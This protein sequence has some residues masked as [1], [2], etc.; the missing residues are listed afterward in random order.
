MSAIYRNGSWYCQ[1]TSNLYPVL[2]ITY[3]AKG[4][5]GNNF[6]ITMTR[7]ALSYTQTVTGTTGNIQQDLKSLGVWSITISDGTTTSR[8]VKV[9]VTEAVIY[10]VTVSYGYLFGYDLKQND[11][12]PNTRVTYPE[13]VHNAN[14]EPA[15]MDFTSD[16][17]RCGDWHFLETPGQFFMPKPVMLSAAGAV[18]EYLDPNDYTKTITGQ[19]SHVSD[20]SFDGNAMI[21]WPKIY[22]KRTYQNNTYSFRCS[23]VQLDDD[24]D[25][26]SNY[27]ENNNIKDYFYTPIYFG[28]GSTSRMR[29]LSGKNNLVNT[30]AEQEATAARANGAG[31]DVETFCDRLLIQD[32]AVLISKSTHSQAKFGYGRGNSGNSSAIATGTMDTKGMF[33]GDTAG[34]NGVKIFGMQNFYGNLWRRI[35]GWILVNG[36]QKVKLTRGTHDGSTATDYNMTGDGYITINGATPTGSSGGYINGVAYSSNAKNI[37]LP[38]AANGSETTYDCDGLWFNNSSVRVAFV[39]GG[40]DGAGRVGL[41]CSILRDLASVASSNFGAAVAFR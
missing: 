3:N 20:E 13:E 15:Y 36:V 10:Y 29:S 6:T 28:S 22:V 7:G 38:Y 19:A 39:G 35:R 9:I 1:S 26:L 5:T 16:E 37:R 21:Q 23:D 27:D 4:L 24:Y 8:P 34:Y 14:Y 40:W 11:S 25:C 41:F 32:L 18:V 2:N 12:N 33:W 30:T 31:W 17:F